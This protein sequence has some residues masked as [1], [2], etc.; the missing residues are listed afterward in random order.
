MPH[1]KTFM[2]TFVPPITRDACLP[3]Y[4][5]EASQYLKQYCPEAT[6]KND[7]FSAFD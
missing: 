5:T 7:G 6:S 4:F 3:L 1:K 2:E